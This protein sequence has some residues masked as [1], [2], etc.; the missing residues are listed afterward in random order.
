MYIQ[1]FY[2]PIVALDSKRCLELGP[3]MAFNGYLNLLFSKNVTLDIYLYAINISRKCMF[4]KT[5]N[6]H[7]LSKAAVFSRIIYRTKFSFSMSVWL[8]DKLN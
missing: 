5:L 1:E 4:G 7:L 2:S 3:R 6:E 8:M